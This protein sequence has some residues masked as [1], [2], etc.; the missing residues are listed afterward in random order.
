[1]KSF[2]CAGYRMGN[3]E[4]TVADE[5]SSLVSDASEYLSYLSELGIKGLEDSA[6]SS[7]PEAA[8]SALARKRNVSETAQLAT[9]NAALERN[10]QASTRIES[11][12]QSAP[13]SPPHRGAT[14]P[15]KE[16]TVMAKRTT[17]KYPDAEPPPPQETLFGE[18]KPA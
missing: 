12:P 13:P 2:G 18:I 1:M 5:L 3:K 10:A 7:Q 14:Q 11:S 6:H 4:E 8:K 15:S 9:N 17:K 16:Q